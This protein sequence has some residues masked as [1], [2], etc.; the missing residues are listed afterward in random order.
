MEP[1]N[2]SVVSLTL[3]QYDIV[4]NSLSFTIAAMG[5]AFVFFLMARATVAYK[6][7]RVT[8]VAALIVGI[9]CY[10]YVRMFGSWTAAYTHTAGTNGY[11]PTG[12]L[13]NEAYRYADWLLTVP[14]LLIELIAVLYI[15]G[16]RR[17]GMV[18]NL[19][20]AAVV[21]IV[22]GYPGEVATDTPTRL[23]WGT[24]STIPFVYILFVLWTEVGEAMK[25]ET[26]EVASLLFGIRLLL[27]ASWGVYPI[28]YLMPLF[29]I[30]AADALVFK[31]V[32]YS[33]A[34]VVAKPLYGLM[35]YAIARLKT[36]QENAPAPDGAS[37]PHDDTVASPGS[38]AI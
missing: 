22:T 20:I 31:Q 24:I 9:A 19:V 33:I 35:I 6:F 14:L 26:P 4:Y 11:T 17:A 3:G 8:E 1:S 10:H 30:G 23:I 29:P 15:T 32:G 5:A 28:A 37:V 34:D 38:K 12:E 13:F 16:N 27:L 2:T 21:M 36:Q 25:R 7:Q 18:R